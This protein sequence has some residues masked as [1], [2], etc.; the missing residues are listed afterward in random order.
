MRAIKAQGFACM[1]AACSP[2]ANMITKRTATKTPPKVI[3]SRVFIRSLSKKWAMTHTI[4]GV[5]LQTMPTVDTLKYFK[6]INE[7]KIEKAA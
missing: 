5:R 7:M 1:V 6:L 4:S 3:M 2:F